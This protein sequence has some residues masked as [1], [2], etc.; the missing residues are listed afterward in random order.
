MQP[1]EISTRLREYVTEN[2]LYTRQDYEFSDTDSLLGHGIIDSMGVIE[3]ITFVQ[4]EFGI[5][6]EEN[7]IIEENFGTL[8]AITRFIESKR[9]EDLAA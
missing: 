2:F 1:H 9:A 4:D 8:A 5:S 6:V 7:E 3:L